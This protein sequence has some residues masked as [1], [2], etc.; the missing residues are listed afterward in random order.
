MQI[1]FQSSIVWK[2]GAFKVWGWMRLYHQIMDEICNTNS[3]EKHGN[4]EKT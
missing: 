2:L 1:T 3:H 4:K